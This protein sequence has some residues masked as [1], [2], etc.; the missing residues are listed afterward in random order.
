MATS[1]PVAGGCVHKGVGLRQ[2]TLSQVVPTP[3]K[4]WHLYF[5][6]QVYSDHSPTVK[7]IQ[8]FEKYLISW[9][10]LYNFSDLERKG[11]FSIDFKQLQED[12]IIRD[13][14]PDLAAQLKQTP[15]AVIETLGLAMH[16]LVYHEL[17]KEEAWETEANGSEKVN[18]GALPFNLAKI[19][20]RVTNYDTVTPLKHLKANCYGK[21][22]SV[23]GTVVRVSNIKPLCTRMAFECTN[24]ATIQTAILPDGKYVLPSK[25]ATEDC[26]GRTFQPKRS[27]SLTETIDWQT[28]RVQE[29]MNDDRRET[30]RIPRTV[31]C[32]LTDDLVD[33]CVPGDVVTISGV[34]KVMG[35]DEGM[36]C[37]FYTMAHFY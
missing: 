32:E 3:Y 7:K 27:H 16:Q 6:E 21:F 2:T 24:C 18:T 36:A 20:C 31:D 25:C 5:P 11:H 8:L 37:A 17:L 30:G 19:H 12:E 14:C 10:S 34:V 35:A 15:G 29:I 4:G 13:G 33:S 28:I 1:Q 22:V 26:R 23:K 9:K